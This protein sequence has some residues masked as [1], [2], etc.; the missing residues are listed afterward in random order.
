MA[1]A[2]RLQPII[3]GL[4]LPL[5]DKVDVSYAGSTY[6]VYTFKTI[7]KSGQ[8]DATVRTVTIT[9]TDSGKGTITQVTSV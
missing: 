4:Q 5:W 9:Y 7:G 6:D 8:P 3:E 2:E 1:D